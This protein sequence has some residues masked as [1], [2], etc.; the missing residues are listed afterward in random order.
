[1][2]EGPTL[3]L[4]PR[5]QGQAGVLLTPGAAARVVPDAAPMHRAPPFSPPRADM[6]PGRS[7]LKNTLRPSALETKHSESRRHGSPPH[8]PTPSVSF[9]DLNI[10]ANPRNL[11]ANVPAGMDAASQLAMMGDDALS[12]SDSASGSGD[13]AGSN[14]SPEDMPDAEEEMPDAMLPPGL[15]GGQQGSQPDGGS[16]PDKPKPSAGSS[17]HKWGGMSEPPLTPGDKMQA[18]KE[19]K[20]RNLKKAQLCAKFER[21]NQ[22]RKVKIEYN[23]MMSLEELEALDERD[24]YAKRSEMSVKVLRRCLVFFCKFCE[25]ASKRFPKL[26]LELEGWSESV[27]LTLDTYDELLYDI[28]DEY[29]CGVRMNP[30]LQ[31]GVQLTTNALMYSMAKK[32][33]ESPAV[34]QFIGQMKFP[35]QQQQQQPNKANPMPTPGGEIP[36]MRPGAPP[37]NPLF[38]MLGSM[39]GGGVGGAATMGADDVEMPNGLD[40]NSLFSAFGNAM[41][42]AQNNAGGGQQAAAAGGGS[43]EQKQEQQGPSPATASITNNTASG[44]QSSA[45]IIN[46]GAPMGAAAGVP[47]ALF[48]EQ[49]RQA[50]AAAAPSQVSRGDS[51]IIA[52]PDLRGIDGY[53]PSRT[54]AAMQRAPHVNDGLGLPMMPMSMGMGGMGGGMGAAPV[55]GGGM[56]LIN[57]MRRQEDNQA[58]RMPRIE[59]IPE[60][61]EEDE[62]PMPLEEPAET[63]SL[64]VPDPPAANKKGPRSRSKVNINDLA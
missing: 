46:P 4:N 57:V 47:D 52:P 58:G 19:R 1:M 23:P 7:I 9:S 25:A 38:S 18:E 2:S 3:V 42:Q 44:P 31:L 24:G 22:H 54:P 39:F 45:A 10:V 15:F 32:L 8:S 16:K 37:S 14:E 17:W 40:L 13:S 60:D 43:S 55:G 63:K 35:P 64:T 51:S 6:P 28:H 53:T 21:R 5:G 56:L 29:F 30:L 11:R 26:G 49:H 59:E 62:I 61:E 48:T 33:M 36:L 27:Y 12:G 41:Q 50:A 34:S 20:E